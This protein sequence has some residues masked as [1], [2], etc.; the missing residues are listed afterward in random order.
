MVNQLILD[1]MAMGAAK[2]GEI[3][4]NVGNPNERSQWRKGA[5]GISRWEPLGPAQGGVNQLILD[6]A[7]MGAAKEGEIRAN[8][9]NPNERSQ[10][11]KGADGISRWEPLGSASSGLMSAPAVKYNDPASAG[12]PV[13]AMAA[14]TGGNVDASYRTPLQSRLEGLANPFDANYQNRLAGQ[15]I[16]NAERQ[17]SQA[18]D[19]TRAMLASRGLMAGG[20]TGLQ[21]SLM[22]QA[23]MEAAG[24][25]ER[26]LTGAALDTATR[27]ADFEFRRAGAIDAYNRG[28]MSDAQALSLLPSQV[29]LAQ[30]QA[31][32]AKIDAD[33]AERT[34]GARE[35]MIGSQADLAAAQAEITRA[36]AQLK[37]MTPAQQQQVRD[38][39]VQEAVSNGLIKEKE[40]KAAEQLLQRNANEWPDWGKNILRGALVLGGAALGGI[41]GFFAGGVGAVPGAMAGTAAGATAAGAIR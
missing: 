20:G 41:G 35:R 19:R 31:R 33:V 17:Y 21:A 10:W 39:I 27:G 30:S 14:P 23:A 32:G 40:V 24:A 26:A 37:A 34:V 15:G 5:D 11:R 3:R 8:V 1:Q 18:A 4:A 6:Q 9:G 13:G 7:A 12:K 2:E 25:R 38:A 16:S 28:L 22:N 29:S 36:D